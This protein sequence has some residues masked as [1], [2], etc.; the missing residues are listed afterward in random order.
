MEE[1]PSLGGSKKLKIGDLVQWKHWSDGWIPV[2]G[3][4][5]DLF[6]TRLAGRRIAM[7]RVTTTSTSSTMIRI[8]QEL[9]L[10]PLSLQIISTTAMSE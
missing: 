1:K 7:A 10:N 9:E 8:G 3:V 4:V 2:T 5:T 6:T